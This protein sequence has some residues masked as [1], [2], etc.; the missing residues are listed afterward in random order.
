MLPPL[1]LCAVPRVPLFALLVRK[2]FL[3]ALALALV[4]G[5]PA[6]GCRVVPVVDDFYGAVRFRDRY[7]ILFPPVDLLGLGTPVIVRRKPA[8]GLTWPSRRVG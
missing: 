5:L 3:P 4:F 6:F 7:R 1:R 8:P 2:P